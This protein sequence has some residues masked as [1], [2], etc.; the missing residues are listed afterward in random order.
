MAVR[1]SSDGSD[2][3]KLP[4]SL[5]AFLF[6]VGRGPSFI[7]VFHWW[8][9]WFSRTGIENKE[10]ES[11]CLLKTSTYSFIDSFNK[12]LSGYHVP[13]T[14]PGLGKSMI[15]SMKKWDSICTN[16]FYTSLQQHQLLCEMHFWE[17]A[18]YDSWHSSD[19]CSWNSSV[20]FRTKG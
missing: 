8:F 13:G 16:S 10:T 3:P 18:Y 15:H 19:Q 2:R 17:T 9:R 20:L 4:W 12:Y 14:I 1:P 6:Q 11:K 5:T 7:H